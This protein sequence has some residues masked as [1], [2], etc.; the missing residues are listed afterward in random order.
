MEN[1]GQ[2][3]IREKRDL[4][5]LIANVCMC[6]HIFFF[7]ILALRQLTNANEFHIFEAFEI[8][9]VG[10]GHGGEKRDLRR[11]M[12]N[13]RMCISNLKIIILAYGNIRKRTNLFKIF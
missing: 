13:V 3:Q 1:V 11:S 9:D 7:I 8:E 10:P 2:G 5:L 4:R 12:A 6:V